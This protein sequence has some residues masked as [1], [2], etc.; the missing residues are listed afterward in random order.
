MQSKWVF[1]L[2][3]CRGVGD[4]FFSFF[5]FILLGFFPCVHAGFFCWWF[6]FVSVFLVAFWWSFLFICLGFLV[7][8]FQACLHS[9]ALLT[10]N[11]CYGNIAQLNSPFCSSYISYGT[12]EFLIMS[13]IY[14][15]LR[16]YSVTTNK[17]HYSH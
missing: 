5:A 16:W 7:T 13:H 1:F 10:E 14:Y 11:E 8:I 3:F 17:N 6:F 9:W 4:F 12:P 15:S 2:F